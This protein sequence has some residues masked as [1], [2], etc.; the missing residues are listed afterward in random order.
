MKDMADARSKIA[1]KLEIDEDKEVTQRKEHVVAMYGAR[2]Q[3]PR[4]FQLTLMEQEE[5]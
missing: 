3:Q 1:I 2:V 5:L 4:V